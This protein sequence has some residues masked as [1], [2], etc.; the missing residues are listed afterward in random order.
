MRS[1][2]T[3]FLSATLS[4]MLVAGTVPI[5]AVPAAHAAPGPAEI[6]VTEILADNTGADDFEYVEI[7]NVSN[8]PVDLAASGISFAYSY[9]DSADRSRDISLTAE[10]LTLAKGETALLWVSYASGAVDTSARTVEEF[11]AEVSTRACRW[12]V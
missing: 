5:L 9:A 3:R 6:V 4:T 2:R 8:A 1:P 10:P 7:H 11:R 12:P